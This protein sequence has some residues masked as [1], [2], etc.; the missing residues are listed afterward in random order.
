M[1]QRAEKHL[2]DEWFTPF[3]KNARAALMFCLL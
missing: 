3:D 2:Q 1:Q